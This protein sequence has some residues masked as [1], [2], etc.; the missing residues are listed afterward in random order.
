M[1]LPAA[2][3]DGLY[4]L[5]PDPWPKK[6]HYKRRIISQDNLDAFARVL[7]PGATLVMTTDVDD[8]AEW[9]LAEAS[10]HPAFAWAPESAQNRHIAPKGWIP[11]RYEE[12]GIRAGRTQT[13]LV[14]S[15]LT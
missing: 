8:L 11:T 13:Y 2:S 10:R 15:R 1:A 4:V 12:K 6:R 5:N 7:K 3:L 14:F 9:M